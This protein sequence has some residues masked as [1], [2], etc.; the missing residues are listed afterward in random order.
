MIKRNWI[1]FWRNWAKSSFVEFLLNSSPWR[2]IKK[3]LCIL[4]LA[5]AF[6]IP[7]AFAC[8]CSESTI[9][10]PY[11]T[12]DF[13]GVVKILKNYKNYPNTNEYYRAD[14]EVLD[15]Y[16]GKN[17]KHLYI[18]G[19]NGVDSYNSCGTFIKEGEVRL[20]FGNFMKDKSIST[21]LCKSY[22]SPEEH[23]YKRDQVEEKLT[24]LKRFARKHTNKIPNEASIYIGDFKKTINKDSVN[25][26]SLVGVELKNSGEI[27]KIFNLTKDNEQLRSAL[28]K[29]FRN[30]FNWKRIKSMRENNTGDITLFFEVRPYKS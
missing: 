7:K 17:L 12:A 1:R 23:Y 15:L 13:V 27:K 10:F 3:T 28:E 18:L 30:T 22:K 5:A 24:L 9:T 26:T 11:Q 25:Y 4:L 21:Y 20:I 6:S 14:V 2:M 8:Y 16:K 29:Y 19:S